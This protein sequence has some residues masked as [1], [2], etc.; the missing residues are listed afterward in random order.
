MCVVVSWKN[1]QHNEMNNELKQFNLTSLSVISCPC[2]GKK[3]QHYL[4]HDFFLLFS[5][6]QIKYVVGFEEKN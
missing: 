4:H 1:V 2:L 3:A 6:F 5:L